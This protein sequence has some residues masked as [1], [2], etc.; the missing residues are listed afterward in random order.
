MRTLITTILVWALLIGFMVSGI[1]VMASAPGQL[2]VSAAPDASVQI[3]ERVEVD[4]ENLRL[5]R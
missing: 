1:R 4:R 5:T 2:S 3:N